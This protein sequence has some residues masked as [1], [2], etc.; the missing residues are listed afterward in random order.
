LSKILAA[1]VIILLSSH[2]YLVGRGGGA[3]GEAFFRY[4]KIDYKLNEAL[5]QTAVHFL[6]GRPGINNYTR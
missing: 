4:P 3:R 5:E 2:K 6:K 1:T